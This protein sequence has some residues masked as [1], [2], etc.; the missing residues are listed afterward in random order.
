MFTGFK[1]VIRFSYSYYQI[2]NSQ[3]PSACLDGIVHVQL[4]Q[5]NN[6]VEIIPMLKLSLCQ[7]QEKQVWNI[8][9]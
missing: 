7:I 4:I 2:K 3:A 1:K 6:V 8:T 5:Y 9:Q